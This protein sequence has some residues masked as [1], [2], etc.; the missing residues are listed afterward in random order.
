MNQRVG[1]L[2]RLMA[3]QSIDAALVTGLSNVRYYTGFTG[4][5]S[6]AL[7]D[8]TH[9]V[10][11]TDFRYTEQAEG[12]CEGFTVIEP[13]AA[14]PFTTV[15]RLCKEWGVKRLWVEEEDISWDRYNSMHNALKG[16]EIVPNAG[17]IKS[18]RVVK[19]PEEIENIRRAQQIAERGFMHLLDFI[20]PGMT[21]REVALELEF[22]TRR[23]GSEA[24]AFPSI[25][26]AGPHGAMPHAQLS[27]TKIQNGDMVVMDFGCVYRGYR[28]DMTRT[29][30]VGKA[31]DAMKEVYGIVLTAQQAALD[32]L[33]AGMAEAEGD[34]LS[35]DIIDRAG[36]AKQFGHG[37]GHGVGLDIHEAP[38]LS[39]LAKG[40]L[41]EGMVV[42]VEPGI[43]LPGK[44]G[45]RI[46]DFVVVKA[47]GIENLTQAPKE[48]IEL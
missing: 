30:A 31:T 26:A 5:D 35:R 42:T 4:D 2:R 40:T 23:E 29:I 6:M 48:L 20:K 3:E 12:E 17:V 36:Y 39:P 7:I 38:R 46:E 37:L 43:Y 13:E 16:I 10:F 21:E 14:A 28:S 9:A 25:I 8:G 24:M 27:D 11:L 34:C 19:E 1:K 41:A 18:V 33:R 32:G 15:D 45:V 47:D 44:F 22:F